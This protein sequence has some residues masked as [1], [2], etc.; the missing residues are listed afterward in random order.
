MVDMMEDMTV[1]KMDDMTVEKTDDTT[2]VY[3]VA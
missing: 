1:V 2:V 3:L